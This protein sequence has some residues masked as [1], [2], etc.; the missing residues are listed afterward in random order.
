[1]STKYHGLWLKSLK[2]PAG[3]FILTPSPECDV[4]GV[5]S[6]NCHR[7]SPVHC[8]AAYMSQAGPA[9]LVPT[10]LVRHNLVVN[11]LQPLASPIRK[12]SVTLAEMVPIPGL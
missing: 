6:Q 4:F 8:N 11:V 12:S 7:L 2:R 9:L 3:E 1:M 5:S 10:G